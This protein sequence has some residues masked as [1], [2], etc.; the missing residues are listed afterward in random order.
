MTSIPL[1][2]MSSGSLLDAYCR[3]RSRVRQL[4][5]I[6]GRLDLFRRTVS[7]RNTTEWRGLSLEGIPKGRHC[8]AVAML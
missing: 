6:V 1:N 3:G 4:R 7:I 2:L 5:P 8:K